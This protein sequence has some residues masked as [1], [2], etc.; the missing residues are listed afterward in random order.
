MNLSREPRKSTKSK[1]PRKTAKT[2]APRKS[3]ESRNPT[4][5]RE[6][7]R[8][9]A[10]SREPR[11]SAKSREPRKSAKSRE[12][13]KSA[14]SREPRKS[15]KTR[16]PRKSAKSREPRKSS[17]T[18]EPRKSS[19]TR[20]PRK[21][22]KTREPRKSATSR[23]PRK[24]AKSNE[25]NKEKFSPMLAHVYDGR[26]PTGYFLSE[27]LDGYRALFYNGPNGGEFFSRNKNPFIAPKWFI[28]NISKKIPKGVLLDGELYIKR[29]DFEGMGVV[30]KKDPVDSEWKMVKYMVFDLPLVDRPFKERYEM[31]KS[32]IKG[33][34]NVEVV[35]HI[36]IKS[37]DHFSKLHKNWTKQGGEGSMLRD[38][39]SYYENNRSHSLLKV[40]DFFDDEVVVENVELGKGKNSD[41]M[42]NLIVSWAP[43]SKKSYK[44]T[45]EVG[46]GFTDDQRKNWEKLFKKGTMLTIKYFEIQK[47]GKPRFPVFQNIYIKK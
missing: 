43:H 10:K 17:K 36:Q 32:M 40:K 15:T 41:V 34:N 14:K 24:S 31:L 8:K 29:G 39:N 5:S 18:R 45:F 25:F 9:S 12:P 28:D 13:R 3:R 37:I 27:K 23:E 33:I 2:R 1:E 46:S 30:R 20:E 16:E 44:G 11:K 42:G 22:S 21:S 47:S 26:D 7:R 4:K 6:P 38:P 19:K 35:D